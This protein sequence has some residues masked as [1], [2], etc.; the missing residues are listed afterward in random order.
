M[1][2]PHSSFDHLAGS[3]QVP[4]GTWQDQV[5]ALRVPLALGVTAMAAAALAGWWLAA[6]ALVAAAPAAFLLPLAGARTRKHRDPGDGDLRIREAL[7]AAP[8]G[9]IV[10]NR[11]GIIELVNTQ[12]ERLFEMRREQMVGMSVDELV[13]ESVRYGHEANRERFHANP[14]ARAMGQGRDLWAKRG[15]GTIFPVEIGLN[16][17]Q[18][19]ATGLVLASIIDISARKHAERE[20]ALREQRMR[21]MLEAAPAGMMVVNRQGFIEL[22]NTQ[23]ER[24]FDMRRDQL[25]G[26]S[27]DALVPDHVRPGHAANRERFHANPSVRAMGHGRDLWAKRGDGTVFP[28]EIGLNPLKGAATGLVLAS[29]IDISARKAAEAQVRESEAEI[30]RMNTQLEQTIAQRTAELHA[31][32]EEAERANRAKDSLLANVSHEIRTPLNAILGTAQIL[33]RGAPPEQLQ[34]LVRGI[35]SAG[36]SLMAVINDLLDMAKIEAGRFEIAHEP[37]ALHDVLSTLADVLQTIAAEKGLWLRIHAVPPEVEAVI[38]DAQRVGQVLYNL[39]GNAIKFTE[40]GGVD[41]RVEV[42]AQRHDAVDLRFS[43]R[44]TGPGVAADIMPMLFSPFVQADQPS[45]KQLGGTGLGLAICRQLVTLMQGDIGVD[46][47]PGKGSDFWFRLTL[48]TTTAS[49]ITARL[50]EGAPG[51]QRLQDLRVLIVDDAPV[52]R[53]I[54]RL[55]LEGEGA[56]VETANDGQGALDRLRAGPRDF[57][58]VLMDVQMPHMDGLEA[59]RQIREDPMLR[60][61]PVLALTA[62]ALDSQRELAQRAGMDD[63]IVK[64]FEMDLMVSTLLRIQQQPRR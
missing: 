46:T 10:V 49:A 8:A 48:P 2:H 39:T 27:I 53:E 50:E 57:D 63:Y 16:P 60:G 43:V 30:R 55:L 22:V 20:L 42:L 44:D 19:A 61:L 9:M 24:L 36:R 45:H 33:E 62:A 1:N 59:T 25:I 11:R 51:V 15:D 58:L 32:K 64:P 12:A 13:P 38:G 28:V 40:R 35:R 6:P 26:M 3:G 52:N 17:L 34:M 41:V 14:S 37:F 54:A 4:R 21:E 56:K 18:G 29:I 7:E 31:A 47:Q 5:R 23:A